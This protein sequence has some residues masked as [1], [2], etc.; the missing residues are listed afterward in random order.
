M[1]SPR[2]GKWNGRLRFLEGQNRTHRLYFCFYKN[3]FNSPTV[4]HERKIAELTIR[5]QYS[6]LYI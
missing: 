4:K 3:E 5:Q 1:I 2:E 6:T